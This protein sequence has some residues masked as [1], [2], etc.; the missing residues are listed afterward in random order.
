[1]K[2]IE[3]WRERE[4]E[5]WEKDSNSCDVT[6]CRAA[7]KEGGEERRREEKRSGGG[8]AFQFHVYRRKPCPT[9]GQP[10][11]E[12]EQCER[13]RERWREGGKTPRK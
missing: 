1:M 2:P 9:Q 8:E 7:M 13:E 5:R 3:K 6:Y 11:S 12:R 4:R 10:F